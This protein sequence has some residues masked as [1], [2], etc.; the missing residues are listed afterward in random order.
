LEV[1]K[2]KTL[3]NPERFDSK[4]NASLRDVKRK[5]P[6]FDFFNK[7]GGGVKKGGE[8]PR[9]LENR[10][11]AKGQALRRPSPQRGIQEA[12]HRGK[13]LSRKK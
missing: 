10:E 1:Q 6:F 3:N 7:N 13:R 8:K 5:T 4:Y 9:P 2:I 11:T 12:Y